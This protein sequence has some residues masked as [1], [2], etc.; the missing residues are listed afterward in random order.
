MAG[1]R[2]P[3]VFLKDGKTGIFDLFGTGR[4]YTLVDFTDEGRY[5]R[6]FEGEAK[7]LNIPLKAIHLQDEEHARSVWE[8]NAVLIRPDDHVA[9]RAKLGG[10]A[11]EV[12]GLD[13]EDVL[14][15]AVGQKEYSRTNRVAGAFN[16]ASESGKGA[17]TGT[18]G[19][20]DQEQVEMRAAF[21]K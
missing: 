14:L 8:R 16:D 10:T 5:I 2:P 12:D 1:G 7:K 6:R 3:H 21:Q 18:V 19:S 17:F 4:E 11:G 20:V 15:V 9:W 13:V